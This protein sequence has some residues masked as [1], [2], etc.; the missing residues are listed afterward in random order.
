LEL[1]SKLGIEEGTL[2]SV[3]ESEGSIVLRPAPPLEGGRVVGVQ[4]HGKIIHELD[5]L[6]R[7]W[8]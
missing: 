5:K 4:E 2:L 1:R 6:R 8:R 3:K 7:K